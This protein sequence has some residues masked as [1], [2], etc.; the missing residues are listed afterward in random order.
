MLDWVKSHGTLP[1][2]TPGATLPANSFRRLKM[3]VVC[4]V[5]AAGCVGLWTLYFNN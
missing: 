3:L 4:A 1:P 2:D 5:I